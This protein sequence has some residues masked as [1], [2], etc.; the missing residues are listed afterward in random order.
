MVNLADGRVEYEIR[1]DDSKLDEDLDRAQGKVE[2][3]SSKLG[4]VAS[5]SAKAIGAGFLATG[6]AAIGIGVAAVNS[7]NDMDKAMNGFIAS[8]GKGTDEAERYQGVLEKIYANNYGEGF[9][10]IAGSMAQ[11]TKNMGDL[12][13]ADLQNVTESA[14][15]LRDTFEYEIPES[16]KAAK[17][18]MDNFGVSGE[19]AM[20][21]IAAG[22]Q[23]GL[24]YSG[25]LLDS[26]SEYSVQFSKVG[27]NADDMFKIFQ[28]GA[29]SGA[30]N[31]DKVGDAVKELSIRVIDGS[32]TTADGFEQIG[33]NAAEMSSKFAEGGDSAKEAFSQV[34]EALAGMDDPLQQNIAGTELFGTQWEDL[35]PDVVSQLADIQ[36]GAYDTADAMNGIKDVKYDSLGEMFDGLMK[37]LN[38]LLIP[39]G[40]MLIPLLSEVIQNILPVVQEQLPPLIDLIGGLFEQLMPIIE[41]ALP[42]LIQLFSDLVPQL[43]P[44]ISEVLPILIQL[45]ADLIPQLMPIIEQILPILIDLF[46]T[47]APP[48]IEII[49]KLLPPLIELVGAV[50]PI[51]ET[52]ISLL[53]PIIDLFM[54][55]LDPIIDLINGAIVPLINIL[56][57][58]INNYLK[59]LG[60][61]L[62]VLSSVFQEIFKGISG[63]VKDQIKIITNTLSNLIDFIKNVFTGNWRGAWENVKNIFSNI[64]TGIGNAFKAPINFIID[65]INGFINGLNKIEIPDWVPVV[66]GKGF[67]IA[68]IPRLKVGMDYVPSDYFPAYLDQGE[69]VLTADE[70]ALYRSTG[71]NLEN[72]LSQK[73]LSRYESNNDTGT[74]N[75]FDFANMFDGANFTVREEADI[76]K[77]ARELQSYTVKSARAKGVKW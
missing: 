77:I 30:F 51:F 8:T 21:M 28:K 47:L 22:A 37:N 5:T 72:L 45:F 39:L 29:D 26:I 65:G 53:E 33:L 18:L 16:T 12:N 25:E 2:K 15:A 60:D 40:E 38:L 41:Q 27:L 71:S 74:V 7:A 54:E 76:Q 23:N 11:V 44:I 63:Y 67:H 34:I 24:D 75:N 13:D 10:D 3:S 20:S 43:T 31:L 48:I 19:D 62:Q 56:T 69:A 58:L 36:S 55:L 42:V 52:L 1:G 68:N 64:A 17:A 50:L 9:E 61:E 49:E 70:A 46:K 57:T 14:F 6:A 35:G 32:D 73:D 59:V 66:G 4:K